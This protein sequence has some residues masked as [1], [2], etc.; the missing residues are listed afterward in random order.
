[1][2][3]EVDFTKIGIAIKMLRA[4]KHISQRYLA[5]LIGISQTHMSNIESGRVQVNLRLMAKMADVFECLLDDF[6]RPPEHLRGQGGDLP[7]SEE[8]L[9]LIIK[10]LQLPGKKK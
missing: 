6:F 3:S 10:L 5:E 1:M 4:R 2:Y 9:V 8:D 7:Y